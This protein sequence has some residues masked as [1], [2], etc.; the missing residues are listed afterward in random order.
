VAIAFVFGVIVQW[1]SRL[2][3][4]FTYEKGSK[5][6][7]A[8][9]GGFSVT[10]IIWFLLIKGLK[11]SSLMIPELDHFIKENTWLMLSSFLVVFTV[12]MFVL[13]LL[14]VNVLKIVVMLGTFALAMAFA[15]NDLVNFVGVPLTG[16]ESYLDYTRNSGGLSSQEFMMSSLSESGKSSSLFLVISG[17]IMVLSLVFS[18]K[19]QNVAKTSVGLSSQE[20]GDEMFGSSAIARGIVRNTS[21]MNSFFSKHLPKSFLKWV[22]ILCFQTIIL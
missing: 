8:L 13:N 4:T 17:V 22:L 1:L 19:A 2:L 3:F 11:G 21:K 5:L 14:K 12:L 7:M 15:G 9:F 20:E 6:K 16:L 10:C 18:K